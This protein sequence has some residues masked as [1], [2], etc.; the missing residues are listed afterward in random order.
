MSELV[1]KA[2]QVLNL[3]RLDGRVA[4]VIGGSGGLGEAMCLA[5]AGAG[6]N[7][8]VVS[9]RLPECGR[10]AA[11][12]ES[13]GQEALAVAADATSFSSLQQ[14]VDQVVDRWGRIDILVHAAGTVHIEPTVNYPEEE[15]DR[16][17][18]VNLKSVFLACKAVAPVMLK[19]KYGKIINVSSVRSFQGRAGD[20]SY[21]ASKA[22]VNLMTKSFALEWAKDNITVNAIA[23]TYVRTELNTFQLDDP[24]FGAWVLSRIPMGRTGRPEDLMGAALFLASDASR[25]ITGHVL[26]VDGGWTAA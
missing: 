1:A 6:A 5:F 10:V 8:A 4:V 2:A 18:N 24:E 26:L 21:P 23:P 22:G 7:V 11:D 25:F 16:V 15:Y 13:L 17:M 20:P 12:V 14:M 9:R 19:Q 3:F